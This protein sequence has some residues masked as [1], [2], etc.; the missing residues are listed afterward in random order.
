[1]TT[2]VSLDFCQPT[3]ILPLYIF[4]GESLLFSVRSNQDGVMSR[5]LCNHHT[6]H[7]LPQTTA[8]Q[9]HEVPKVEKYTKDNGKGMQSS[10]FLTRLLPPKLNKYSTCK[11][12]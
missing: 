7:I 11:L 2:Y 6:L 3:I 1:M 4:P 9:H 8:A 5:G 10:T 12:E